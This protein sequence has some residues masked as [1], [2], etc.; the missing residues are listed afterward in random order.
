MIDFYP[1]VTKIHSFYQIRLEERYF[2]FECII[3]IYLWYF[4]FHTFT[5]FSDSFVLKTYNVCIIFHNFFSSIIHFY[6][7]YLLH[8]WPSH[9]NLISTERY[10][11]DVTTIHASLIQKKRELCLHLKQKYSVSLSFNESNLKLLC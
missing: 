6:D 8:N 10:H 7:T 11:C 5:I 3:W 9:I 1:E 4:Y 2:V